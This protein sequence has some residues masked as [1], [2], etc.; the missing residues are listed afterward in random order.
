MKIDTMNDIFN[1]KY[2]YAFPHAAWKLPNVIK[3]ADPYQPS[4]SIP[5]KSSVI[6]GIAVATIV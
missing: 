5:P 4:S 6:F 3:K 1:G 2:L